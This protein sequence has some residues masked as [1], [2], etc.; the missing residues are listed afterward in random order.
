MKKQKHLHSHCTENISL[1]WLS[2]FISEHFS[3]DA[4]KFT[5]ENNKLAKPSPWKVGT[6]RIRAV[7]VLPDQVNTP[8]IPSPGW[9]W[10]SSPL[11]LT[12]KSKTFWLRTDELDLQHGHIFT[13]DG[14][15]PRLLRHQGIQ[16]IST[17]EHG[18]MNAIQKKSIFTH[19]VA[20]IYTHNQKNYILCHNP[21]LWNSC[22]FWTLLVR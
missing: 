10:L 17:P 7:N 2:I 13:E 4:Q 21:V 6:A 15:A 8:L 20:Y 11:D 14:R 12:I 3:W 22:T 9:G 5:L 16:I 1:L 18:A 19:A